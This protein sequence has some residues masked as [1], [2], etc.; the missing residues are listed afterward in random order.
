MNTQ[1][2][3]YA[4]QDKIPYQ[5]KWRRDKYIINWSFISWLGCDILIIIFQIHISR[6]RVT[7]SAIVNLHF[8]C[9]WLLRTMVTYLHQKM[10]NKHLCILFLLS[11]W[12]NL[13]WSHINWH[14]SSPGYA[15]N[16]CTSHTFASASSIKPSNMIIPGHHPSRVSM[17]WNVSHKS[18]NDTMTHLH[19]VQNR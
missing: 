8:F 6:P 16:L 15:C 3:Y 2:W 13:H 12:P 19:N 5:L 9:C 1:T 4:E 10:T 17:K 7:G 14:H 11:R 18:Q